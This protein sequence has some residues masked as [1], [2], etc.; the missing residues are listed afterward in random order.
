[1]F[2]THITNNQM[3]ITLCMASI[4]INDRAI[5]EIKIV[6]RYK[7]EMKWSFDLEYHHGYNNI[8]DKTL[9]YFRS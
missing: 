7:A 4:H 3:S 2:K 1:M 6:S 5:T 8:S 9:P